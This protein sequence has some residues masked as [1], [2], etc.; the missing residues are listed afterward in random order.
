MNPPLDTIDFFA[1]LFDELG[2]EERC[3][4][5][6]EY[7]LA[8][9]RFLLSRLET[10]Q[11]TILII[12]E[13][14]NLSPEMLEEIRLLSN[15]ETAT[16]KLIQIMLVGQP[17]LG[18]LL[19]RPELR[20]LRQRVALRHQLRPFDQQETAEYIEQRLRR[21]GFTGK[22][23]FKK[24]ALREIYRVSGGTPRVVNILCDS[25]LLHGYSRDL[26]TLDG[27]AI[28]EAATDLGLVAPAATE[29]VTQPPR[30]TFLKWFGWSR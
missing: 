26:L 21:A 8:L 9:N 2:I 28:R 4:T 16:S 5:K 11:S 7:L 17:E 19:A 23:I 24:S 29:S 3:A 1:V 10:N 30:S 6:G 14:Q 18:D 15:L 12:D 13:A 25:A 22:Q 27:A 20:Q